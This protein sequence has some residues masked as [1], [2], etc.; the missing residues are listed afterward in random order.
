MAEIVSLP[1]SRKTAPEHWRRR[2]LYGEVRGVAI[3]LAQRTG[4]EDL[5]VILV[6]GHL[7]GVEVIATVPDT[8]EGILSADAIGKAALRTL[9]LGETEF[10]I[11]GDAA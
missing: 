3:A 1:R 6:G 4:D 5:S 10:T 2:W 11:D 9:E 8:A 7:V